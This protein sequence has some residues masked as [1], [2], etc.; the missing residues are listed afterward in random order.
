MSEKTEGGR[1]S[2]Q[3]TP[4]VPFGNEKSVLFQIQTR[5]F[6]YGQNI[7]DG[8]GGL[9]TAAAL[10]WTALTNSLTTVFSAEETNC[11][12]CSPSAESTE[13]KEGCDLTAYLKALFIR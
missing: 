11:R 2:A 7:Q 6:T 10:L 3:V 13:E 12:S 4:L 5:V 1:T 9:L 8:S